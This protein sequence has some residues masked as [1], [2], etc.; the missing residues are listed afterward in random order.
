MNKIIESLP[1]TFNCENMNIVKCLY[2][3]KNENVNVNKDVK[4]YDNRNNIEGSI[5]S[6]SIYKEYEEKEN[7]KNGTYRFKKGKIFD[8]LYS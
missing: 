2:E 4:I 5:K 8:L 7:I 1:E 6:V 3:I